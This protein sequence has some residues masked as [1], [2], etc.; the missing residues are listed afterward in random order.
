M[1]TKESN[2]DKLKDAKIN[3]FEFLKNYIHKFDKSHVLMLCKFYSF[4]RG[5]NLFC[6]SL[7]Y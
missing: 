5:V 7:E 2:K 3:L 6:K 1:A 4:T